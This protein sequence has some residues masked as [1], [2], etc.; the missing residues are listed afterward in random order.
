MNKIFV[1]LLIFFSSTVYAVTPSNF[2][3][4]FATVRDV[5]QLFYTDAIKRQFVLSDDVVNDQR[6]VSFRMDYTDDK[7]REFLKFQGYQIV[8]HGSVD[9]VSKIVTLPDNL[10][11]FVYTPKS[12]DADYLLRVSRDFVKGHFF[13]DG[14]S[15]QTAN[16]TPDATTQK[17]VQTADRIVFSG[18]KPEIEK[19]KA[20]LQKLDVPPG[21]VLI[22]STVYEV[23]TT[24]SDGSSLQLIGSILNSKFG[25]QI[26]GPV[27]SNSATISLGGLTGVLSALSSDTRFKTISHS[28]VLAR[29]QTQGVM[30]VGDQV[31]VLGTVTVAANGLSQQSVNMVQSGITLTA[32]ATVFDSQIDLNVNEQISTFVSTLTGVNSSPTLKNRQLTSSVTVHDG[33]TIILGGLTQKNATDTKSGMWFFNHLSSNKSDDQTEIVV[34]MRVTLTDSKC[35]DCSDKLI[36]DNK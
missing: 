10:D 20:L 24:Q 23:S 34:I 21:Q 2:D 26:G 31:P 11:V 16:H 15:V 28:S 36:S 35:A 12:R 27:L 5:V 13:G 6:L 4:R 17:L 3:F 29:S 7:L 19:L 8:S 14:V 25:V 1:C 32:T 9:F 22:E 30:T 33:D 18:E